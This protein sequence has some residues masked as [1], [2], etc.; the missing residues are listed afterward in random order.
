MFN[1]S[2]ICI[3]TAGQ[4][5][6]C[7]ADEDEYNIKAK[8]GDDFYENLKLNGRYKGIIFY[9]IPESLIENVNISGSTSKIDLMKIKKIDF[10]KVDD[11]YKDFDKENELYKK[12]VD[13]KNGFFNFNSK[14]WIPVSI[15][16]K[17]SGNVNTFLLEADT[18]L[19][20]NND[21]EKYEKAYKLENLLK[22]NKSILIESAIKIV[23]ESLK[24]DK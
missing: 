11:F 14:K 9:G 24:K 1:T 8:I 15:E 12:S 17:D 23:K 10:L 6:N 19:T 3:G 20:G 2:Y 4:N 16:F 18:I 22:E 5:T 7:K 13:I 21:I